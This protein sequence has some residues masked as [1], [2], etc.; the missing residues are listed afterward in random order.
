MPTDPTSLRLCTLA[1]AEALALV[2]AATFL[3]AFAGTLDGAAIRAH[4]ARNH[5]TEAYTTLLQ[6]PRTQAWLAELA[7]GSAPIGYTLLT[8]PD[9]PLPDISPADLELK[10]IYL[11]SRFYG[12]G[13]GQRLMDQSI[14][15]ARAMNAARLLLGVYQH[16]DRALRFYYRN[17]FTQVGTRVFQIGDTLNNDFILARPL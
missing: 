4:C 16:N 17:G 1:D 12:N 5:S 7:P 15:A 8:P 3:E 9:L 6:K 14:L 13:L 10:R 11:F 2:G